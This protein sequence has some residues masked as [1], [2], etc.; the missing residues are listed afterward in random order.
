MKGKVKDK[1]GR[2]HHLWSITSCVFS[3]DRQFIASSDRHIIFERQ[4]KLVTE[5]A[6]GMGS[7]YQ[8]HGK[9]SSHCLFAVLSF[10]FFFKPHASIYYLPSKNKIEK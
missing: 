9:F 7:E 6:F 1:Q 10:F 8:V 3:E 2:G 5:V 4:K